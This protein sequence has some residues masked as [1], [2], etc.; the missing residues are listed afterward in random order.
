MSLLSSWPLRVPAELRWLWVGR[1]CD[2]AAEGGAPAAGGGHRGV[3]DEE[4]GSDAGR[5]FVAVA[6]EREPGPAGQQA[7]DAG[8]ERFERGLDDEH[9][10]AQPDQSAHLV[11]DERADAHTGRGPQ[12]RRRRPAG[13][14][15]QVVAT[16]ELV[17][18]PA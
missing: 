13:E 4:E 1:S 6:G 18:D 11:A 12:G 2:V 5:Q 9:P 10:G 7:A 8:K 17:A 15:L 14:Q 3:E 16:G